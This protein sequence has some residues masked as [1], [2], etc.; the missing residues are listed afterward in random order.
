MLPSVRATVV[1]RHYTRLTMMNARTIGR[2]ALL[3]LTILGVIAVSSAYAAEPLELVPSETLLCWYGRPAS[4]MGG[5]ETA[6]A[7]STLLDVGTRL[8]AQPLK[9]RTRLWLRVAESVPVLARYPHVL[10]LI[11]AKAKPTQRGDSIEGEDIRF[12]L[13]LRTGADAEPILRI[14]QKIVN[15]QTTSNEAVLSR[16][17]AHG[18]AYQELRDA[19]LPDWCRLAWGPIDDCYVLTVGDGVWP[20]IAGVAAQRDSS[21]AADAWLQKARGPHGGEAMIEVYACAAEIRRRLDPLTS[22]KASAFFAAWEAE[23]VDV[24]YWSLG[25]RGPA[26]FCEADYRMGG[27]T[28]HRVYADSAARDPRLLDAV[29]PGSHYAVYELPLE[30]FV[31]R[32]VRGALAVRSA[33]T[34]RQIEELWQRLQTERQF[35]AQRDI[36]ANLGE[37]VVLLNDPPHPLRVPFAVTALIEIRRNPDRVRE[38]IDRLS[39]AWRA[40]LESAD[41]PGWFTVERA[42]DGIWYLQLGPAATLAWTTTE[43]YIVSSWSPGA[44]REYLSKV[45]GKAGLRR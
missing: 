39:D 7:L 31:P 24:G 23:R 22:G 27:K 3:F 4:Q 2:A 25:L 30:R 44:L 13:I 11:D 32:L 10:A 29:T 34:R 38:G 40:L 15:E 5:E 19:R 42:G 17:E 43:R 18:R 21:L 14:V 6:G 8:A 28:I 26:L 20:Q 9:P 35:D 1:L 16:R 41:E 36:L 45:N 33:D 37:H 12:A